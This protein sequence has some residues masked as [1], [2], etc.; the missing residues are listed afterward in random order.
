M[1]S[2][3]APVPSPGEGGALIRAHRASICGSDIHVVFDGYYSGEYPAA[4]GFSGHEG[5]GVVEASRASGLSEG[6]WVLAVPN[7]PARA[8]SPNI[9][10]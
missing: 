1:E 9:T 5:V 10:S 6:D 8:A 3:E 7:P 2:G 4:P